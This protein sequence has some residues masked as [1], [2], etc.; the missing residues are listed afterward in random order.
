MIN[1]KSIGERVDWVY[2]NRGF[3]I[4]ICV[5]V[6]LIVALTTVLCTTV[7]HC[8]HCHCKHMPKG[9]SE[10]NHS[11]AVMHVFLRAN[12]C[13]TMPAGSV[14]LLRRQTSYRE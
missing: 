5:C 3:P 11:I 9:L 7:L 6:T 2:G 10:L 8:D 1:F 12:L 13:Y 4:K 14:D